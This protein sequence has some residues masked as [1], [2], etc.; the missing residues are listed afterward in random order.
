MGRAAPSVPAIPGTELDLPCWVTMS[1]FFSYCC[2][3]WVFFGHA[4]Y[5]LGF[6]AD[7]NP[8]CAHDLAILLAVDG[9]QVAPA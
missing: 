7:C 3:L 2:A 5:S 9:C 4:W 8:T 1:R 6:E